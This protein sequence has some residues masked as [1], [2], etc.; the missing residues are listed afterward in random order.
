ITVSA[1]GES[2]AS[3][4]IGNPCTLLHAC[5][6]LRHPMHLVMSTRMDLVLAMFFSLSCA[7]DFAMT[8]TTPLRRSGA[9]PPEAV[10][11]SHEPEVRRLARRRAPV[12]RACR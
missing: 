9:I 6:Q 7:G 3:L 1:V 12:A 4:S 8:G 10:G 11:A 2:L 5:S